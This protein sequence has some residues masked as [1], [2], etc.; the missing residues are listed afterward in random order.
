M[1]VLHVC[2]ACFY[3]DNNSYQENLLPRF[4][5]KNQYDVEILASL[6]SFD[7]NGKPNH[8]SCESTYFNE[9]E[10]KVT[11]LNYCFPK[12]VF[13]KLK[14][15]KNTYS[16]LEK[17]KPDII[18]IHG[19]QFIDIKSIIKYKKKYPKVKIFV[20]N[21]CDFSN[22]ARN[23][24]SKNIVHKII[25]RFC[26]KSINKYAEMFYGVL[27]A[28]VEFLKEMYKLP[29]TKCKLLLMGA[30]D[31]LVN[32]YSKPDFVN[33]FKKELGYTENNFIIVTGGKIDMAKIQTLL[34]M[35]A[36]NKIN[37]NNVKLLV[38]GSVDNKLKEEFNSLLSSKIKYVGWISSQDTYKYIS[39]ANL[40]VYPGRHSVLWEQTV[41]Q[42]K[43]IVVK[44]WEGT[45]HIQIGENVKFLYEDSEVEIYNVIIDIIDN[46]DDVF[47][48]MKKS[49]L[50]DNRKKF[51]YSE[52]A[53]ESIRD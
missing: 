12:F 24:I 13:Q 29:N 27:P 10:I 30:D 23:F 15:Y 52:I 9:D 39:I 44:H 36:V 18:F 1:K 40:V 50:S 53:K 31:G 48:N 32:K 42:G 16:E 8:L 33:K 2:L 4:H 34:L 17:S 38:F 20:D 51:L 43:P 47:S 19:L 41:A 11:R 46:K 49:A 14:K 3:I 21:H 28:R 5:K 26:A 7:E 35:K 22:S 6:E 45:T 37:N 25:W